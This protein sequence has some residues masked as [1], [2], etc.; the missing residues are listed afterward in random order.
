MDTL[1]E[2]PKYAKYLKDFL[3]NMGKWSEHETI[4]LMEESIVLLKCKLLPKLKNPSSFSIPYKIS[5]IQF[6]NSLCDLG[7]S[8]NILPY[9]LFKKLDISEVKS[10]MIN[11]NSLIVPSFTQEG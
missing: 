9:S 5:D 6:E 3:T 7:A 2:M 8:V 1:E 10:T 4:I 11:Y